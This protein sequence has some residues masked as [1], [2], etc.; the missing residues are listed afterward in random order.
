[1]GGKAPHFFGS[2]MPQLGQSAVMEMPTMILASR[3]CPLLRDRIALIKGIRMGLDLGEPCLTP[4]TL[5]GMV[6]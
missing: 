3:P 5:M 2:T 1:M 4:T 6:I